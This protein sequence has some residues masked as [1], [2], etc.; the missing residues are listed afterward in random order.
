MRSLRLLR[1]QLRSYS[2]SSR[3]S[4]LPPSSSRARKTATTAVQASGVKT[5]S[6]AAHELRHANPELVS[7]DAF[8]ALH[9]PL[10][11]LPVRLSRRQSTTQ[12]VGGRGDGL[13]LQRRLEEAATE[14]DLEAL[15]GAE[16]VEMVDLAPDGTPQG[17][18]YLTT[19]TAEDSV[20]A[21]EL[22]SATAAWEA[23]EDAAFDEHDDGEDPFE[24]FLISEPA[25]GTHP[26]SAKIARYLA[27]RDPFLPPP[28]PSTVLAVLAPPTPRGPHSLHS[29][30]TQSHINFLRPFSAPVLPASSSRSF[31]PLEPALAQAM[32]DRFLAAA[33]LSHRWQSQ[34]EYASVSAEKME[35]ARRAYHGE[36]V[37]GRSTA[38]RIKRRGDLRVWSVEEGWKYVSLGRSSDATLSPFLPAEMVDLDWV[39]EESQVGE[40]TTSKRGGTAAG[41]RSLAARGNGIRMDS[42]KRK[43]MK[44]ITKH[45]FKKR[46][47]V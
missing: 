4:A 8:F 29:S 40:I 38:G 10:L 44:K 31:A 17:Q 3:A 39:D 20:E 36:D 30:Q 37:S 27:E 7:L 16:L 18:P 5:H 14:L 13:A 35:S 11:E 28:V 33:S 34:V 23:L 24:A 32:A 15:E 46:R 1:P 21:H 9:R 26:W 47:F 6:P 42:T 43:R 12:Q 41:P 25:Q 22:S 19:L 45:K 2:V